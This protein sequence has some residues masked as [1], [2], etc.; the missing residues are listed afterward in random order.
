M[1]VE[2]PWNE[3]QVN[4]LNAYQRNGRFHPFTCPHAHESDR[5]LIAT[6]D[7]WICRRCNYTQTWTLAAAIVWG[8][9]S[10]A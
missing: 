3:E 5:E 2:A 1:R 10:A 8:A 4:A 7:G 6:R 9:Q